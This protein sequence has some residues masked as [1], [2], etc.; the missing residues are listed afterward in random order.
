M[1]RPRATLLIPTLAVGAVLF[2]SGCMPSVS[3]IVEDATG[4]SV[5]ENGATIETD[6]GT[7]EVGTTTEVPADFPAELPQPNGQLVSVVTAPG[8][9]NLTYEGVEGD[10]VDRLVDTFIGSG[11]ELITDGTAGDGR[12][13]SLQSGS[14]VVALIWDGAEGGSKPLIY[15]VSER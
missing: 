9:W 14:W 13:V 3:D 7:I 5:D 1:H 12:A 10:D 2:L 11:Y 6:E 15:G 8:S 4:I